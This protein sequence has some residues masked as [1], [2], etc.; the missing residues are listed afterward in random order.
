VH[1]WLLFAVAFAP[2]AARSQNAQD[3]GVGGDSAAASAA[4]GAA[5]AA[6]HVPLNVLEFEQKMQAKLGQ[7]A[8]LRAH[9]NHSDH[10]RDT[11]PMAMTPGMHKRVLKL[12]NL[13]RTQDNDLTK[14][15]GDRLV[16]V[17]GF[18][19]GWLL[20]WVSGVGLGGVGAGDGTTWRQPCLLPLQP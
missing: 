3:G 15:R 9:H 4:S 1:A 16:S 11:F 5:E 20:G 17:C 6:A 2:R 19:V 10:F 8:H 13:M 18:V 7:F 14:I 12:R